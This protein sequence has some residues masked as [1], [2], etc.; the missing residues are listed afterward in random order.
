MK[1]F[2]SSVFAII[3]ILIFISYLGIRTE[4]ESVDHSAMISGPFTTPQDITKAC[5]GCH[6]DE[7]ADVLQSRHWL[8]LGEEYEADGKV[9]VRTGKRNGFNNTFININSNEESCTSC[10]PSFG[11]KD[12]TFD[13]TNPENIDCLVC[14][15]NSGI[16]NKLIRNGSAPFSGD[17]LLK[18]AQSVGKSKVSNCGTCHF[19]RGGGKDLNHG[20]LEIALLDDKKKLDVHMSEQGFDCVSCHKSENHKIK[21]AGHGSIAAGTNHISCTDCHDNNKK[22][23]HRNKLL[24]R[25]LDAIACESCHIP[26]IAKE[27][28]TLTG[29]NWKT[30]GL[31]E[32]TNLD[33]AHLSYSKMRGDLNWEKNVKP[34]YRW[35]NGKADYYEIGDK[36]ESQPIQMN[37]LNGSISDSKA[38]I[39]PFKII[40][41]KQIYDVV[42]NYLIVPKLFGEDGFENGYDWNK[43]AENGMKSVNLAYSGKFDFVETVMLQPIHHMVAPKSQAIKCTSCHSK[44]GIMDWNELGYS[45]DPMKKGGRVKNKLI[46]D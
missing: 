10:H 28:Y 1:K 9:M 26:S 17:D 18:A 14:H 31:K 19:E 38:K 34:V 45:E 3:I 42:N 15:D 6:V 23:I 24:G 36:F 4:P 2:N 33:D 20:G 22:E 40:R 41:G 7:A 16:Y 30:A 44:N 29:W 27:N 13:F 11:W 12:A 46:K 25:H 35:F 5:I 39:Y 32:D 21:G 43:A 37:V 8:W